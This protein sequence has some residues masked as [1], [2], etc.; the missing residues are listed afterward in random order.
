MTKE[1]PL[2]SYTTP[3][4]VSLEM[5]HVAMIADLV[6]TTG[7]NRSQIMRL[8]IQEYYERNHP[9]AEE[10]NDRPE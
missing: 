1:K 4:S 5:R 7:L 3:Q 8:A 10:T 2:D 9:E 6:Q